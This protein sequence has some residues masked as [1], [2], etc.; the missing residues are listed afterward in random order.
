MKQPMTIFVAMVATVCGMCLS[1]SAEGGS[2]TFASFAPS[3]GLVKGTA[4][5]DAADPA[6]ET[7]Q[8]PGN[9]EVRVSE[10][11]AV[12]EWTGKTWCGHIQG[13]C[14]REHRCTFPQ[15][16]HGQFMER[17]DRGFVS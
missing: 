13:M 15:T 9:W 7:W 14:G 12:K 5:I 17:V 10:Q 8:V 4:R 11:G 2:L 16:H 1:A 6:K 3:A